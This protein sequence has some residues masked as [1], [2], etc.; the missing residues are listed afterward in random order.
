VKIPDSVLA[1]NLRNVYWICGGACGGKTTTARRLAEKHNFT[2]FDPSPLVQDYQAHASYHDQ[3]ALLRHFINFDWYCNQP[4]ERYA[5][6]QTDFAQEVAEWAI[7]DLLRLSSERPV[8][9]AFDVIDPS[10]IMRMAAYNKSAF[11]YAEDVLIEKKLLHRPDHEE[12]L[13]VIKEQT[14]NPEI[15]EQNVIATAMKVSHWHRE[16]A[17]R[18]GCFLHL[19]TEYQEQEDLLPAIEHHFGLV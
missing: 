4:A 11:L 12:I 7:I 6:W 2:L 1:F 19:R 5:R 13:K 9:A 14:K 17:M 16:L 8:V 18:N 3:P 15:T 10:L